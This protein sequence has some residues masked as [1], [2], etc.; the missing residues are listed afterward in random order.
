MLKIFWGDLHTE[1]AW[2]L[3]RKNLKGE[4]PQAKETYAYMNVAYPCLNEKQFGMGETTIGGRRELRNDDGLF[5]IENLQQIVLQRCTTAKDAIKLIGKLVK[6]YGYGDSGECLTFA[7]PKEVWH[8]EIMGAGPLEIGA[9]WAAVRIPDDHVGISANIPRISELNLKDENNYLASD[10]VFSLAEEMGWWDPNSGEKFKFWKAYSGRRPFSDREFFVFNA[11]APGLKLTMDMEELP[12]SIK[13]EK[14]LS[15]RD[16]MAFYRQTYEGTDFDM[17]KNLMVERRPMRRRGQPQPT[18][19]ESQPKMVKSP[20]ASPWM[21]RDMMTLL[22][23]VNP[24]TVERRRTIAISACS[25]SQVIQ[26]RDWL[27]DE[28]GGVA[29]FSFDNPGQS[30][31]IPIFSGT[32]QLPKSFEIGG[33]HRYRTDSALWSFRRANRLATVRWGQAREYIEK[34]VMDFENRAFDELP[35]IE[36]KA[37]ELYN[38]PDGKE[39]S[40]EFLTNYTNH[41][42]HSAMSKW[43]ELGDIFWGFFARGF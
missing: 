29:W 34:A 6:E 9:V 28:I 33:Q 17:T 32:M 21:S 7:D 24:G 16:V 15:V 4:I 12:F 3:R 37:Q 25:Y 31:R 20:I 19:D 26:F 38:G 41:F 27:P 14:K 10:N 22:N 42:A 43:Q 1:T 18:T 36:K 40:R 39:K 13:P 30:P 5:L 11:L 23:K 2:D 35:G 8:F